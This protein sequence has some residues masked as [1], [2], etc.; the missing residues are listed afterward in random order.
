MYVL[1]FTARVVT[2][3]PMN[4]YLPSTNIAKD[5]FP[6]PAS[7]GELPQICVQ[8]VDVGVQQPDKESMLLF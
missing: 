7:H 2:E 1:I 6:E 3:M 4:D 8:S 5:N